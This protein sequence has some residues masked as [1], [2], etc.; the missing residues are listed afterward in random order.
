M[1][2]QERLHGGNSLA[3]YMVGLRG[4]ECRRDDQT[5]IMR[6]YLYDGLGSVLGEVAP[7][8]AVVSSRKLDVYWPCAEYIY[9]SG[10]DAE[11]AGVRGQ[12]GAYD[13]RGDGQSCLYA[14]EVYGHSYGTV[15]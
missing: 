6:W 8:G 7:T 10:R 14:G 3:T 2:V 13:G 11:Q 12:S 1:L 5:S 9:C 15:Y 4:P